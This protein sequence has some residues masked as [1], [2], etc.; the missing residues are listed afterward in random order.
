M[1]YFE[2]VEAEAAEQG[3]NLQ[4]SKRIVD[5]KEKYVYQANTRNNN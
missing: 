1:I 4:I 2:T 5:T 3:G